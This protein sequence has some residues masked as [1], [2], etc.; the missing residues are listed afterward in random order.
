MRFGY[1]VMQNNPEQI[2]DVIISGAYIEAVTK[3]KP[4]FEA[5]VKKYNVNL[6]EK[7]GVELDLS[8]YKHWSVLGGSNQG[9]FTISHDLEGSKIHSGFKYTVDPG[10]E[11][12][13]TKY[14]QKEISFVIIANCSFFLKKNNSIE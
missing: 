10:N 13:D 1:K 6:F 3:L 14:Q 11:N 12:H 7:D 9:V 8:K 4:E 2:E 5:F